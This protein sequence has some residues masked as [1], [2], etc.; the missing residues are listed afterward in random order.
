MDMW[1]QVEMVPGSKPDQHVFTS[2]SSNTAAWS[3]ALSF[4]PWC[5]AYPISIKFAREG[6]YGQAGN[7]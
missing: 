3:V 1:E 2:N 4:K 6:L 7:K 5:S